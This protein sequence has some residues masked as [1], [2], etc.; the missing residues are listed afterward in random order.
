MW[1]LGRAIR[2]EPRLFAVAVA[3]SSVFSLLTIA[4]A[5]VLGAVVG[6]VVVP[7]IDRGDVAPGVLVVAACVIMVVSLGKALGMFARRLGAGAMQY[8]LQARYRRAV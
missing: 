3:G 2:D 6:R 7:A 4:T 5:Y 1:V 8:R